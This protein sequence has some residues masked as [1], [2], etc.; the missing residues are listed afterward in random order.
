MTKLLFARTLQFVHENPATLRFGAA[1]QLAALR[2]FASLD[3]L[4]SASE[5]DLEEFGH[6]SAGI[7]SA[8]AT[9]KSVGRSV[10]ED[11]AVRSID[12]HT[13]HEINMAGIGDSNYPAILASAHDAPPVLYWKGSLSGIDS[14]SAAVVGTREP[15][16]LGTKVAERVTAFLAQSGVSIVSGLALGIDTV[17]H[18]EALAQNGHTVAVLAQGLDQISPASNRYLAHEIVESG[19]AL[20]SEN[21]MNAIVD[22]YEFAKRDRIQ[23]GLSRIVVP[24]QTGLKGGTQNTIRFA[25]AQNRAL[26]APNV[27]DEIGHEKW[28][29]IRELIAQKIATPFTVDDYAQLVSA[30]RGSGIEPNEPPEPSSQRLT[31]WDAEA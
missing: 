20:V 29:G 2:A 7:R 25:Q 27:R 1:S 16:E 23:S 3:H 21:P 14:A 18:R 17:A 15:T 9:L 19:G 12:F 22:K 30:T 10:F 8:Q 5:S 28:A 24:I 13:E 6:A 11:A 4:L 31:I 26:W